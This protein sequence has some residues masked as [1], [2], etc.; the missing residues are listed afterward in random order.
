[1]AQHDLTKYQGIILDYMQKV[2]TTYESNT[3]IGKR[4]GMYA[5]TARTAI[6]KLISL[7]LIDE[8]NDDGQR[9]LKITA[10]GAKHLIIF[11]ELEN[12]SRYD[13]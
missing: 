7:K 9:L 6:I 8:I 12:R 1:M 11:E 4:L 3:A 2:H 5:P 10:L 13:T